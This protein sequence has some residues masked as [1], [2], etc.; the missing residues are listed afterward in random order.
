M[1][2]LSQY[3]IRDYICT[4]NNVQYINM[5]WYEIKFH[6]AILYLG[7]HPAVVRPLHLPLPDGKIPAHDTENF[8]TIFLTIKWQIINLQLHI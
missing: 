6:F 4:K 5:K 1:L 3:L 2:V 8:S 7:G